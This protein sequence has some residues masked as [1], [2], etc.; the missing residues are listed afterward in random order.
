MR[1]FHS[2]PGR[3]NARTNT[4]Y[5]TVKVTLIQRTDGA[6]LVDRDDVFQAVWIPRSRLDMAGK[7]AAENAPLKST[8]EIGVELDMALQKGLV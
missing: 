2:P 1:A 3:E 5:A 7:L 8:I 6:I 4:E